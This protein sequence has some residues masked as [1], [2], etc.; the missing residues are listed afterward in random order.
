MEKYWFFWQTNW[1][2]SSFLHFSIYGHHWDFGT[3]YHPSNL[4]H[5]DRE[6]RSLYQFQFS[7]DWYVALALFSQGP[8][9]VLYTVSVTLYTDHII[10]QSS[11]NLLQFSIG[12][13]SMLRLL[14]S[15]LSHWFPLVP[16]RSHSN[17]YKHRPFSSCRI[18]LFAIIILDKHSSFFFVL[19]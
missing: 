13:A 7:M 3:Q 14:P 18:D 9:S 4:W 16:T 15:E 19:L 1:W 6:S 10:W 2:S 11:R 17:H 12:S 8:Q 5:I